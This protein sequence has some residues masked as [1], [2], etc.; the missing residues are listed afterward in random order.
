[1]AG[2]DFHCHRHDGLDRADTA[3]AL[4]TI[5]VSLPLESRDLSTIQLKIATL[6]LKTMAAPFP[7]VSVFA[8]APEN[9][10]DVKTPHHRIILSC[11][12]A[13]FPHL[14]SEVLLC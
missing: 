1:V 6:R 5:S 8:I 11:A 3:F 2:H 12:A 13:R 14:K 7:D 4:E 10:I 9:S